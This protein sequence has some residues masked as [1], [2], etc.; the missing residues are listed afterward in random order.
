MLTIREGEVKSG[1]QV[2]LQV[3]EVRTGKGDTALTEGTV[4]LSA[5]GT[6][7]A[8]ASGLKAGDE[9]VASFLLDGPWQEAE[10]IIG[11]TGPLVKDGVVQA[12][13]GPAGVHPRTA[14]GTKAD[15]SVVLFEVDGRAPGFS[16]GVET[17]ELG[18]MMK[19][20]GIV[21]AMNLDGEDHRRLLPACREHLKRS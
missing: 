17:T 1:Q 14:I 8:V 4:V 6:A 15:G 16:E 13:V 19:D 7:R 21:Q 9:V 3:A 18:G 5:S 10:L 12:D 2:K 11:G 20:M